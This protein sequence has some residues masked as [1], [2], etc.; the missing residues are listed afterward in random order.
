MSVAIAFVALSGLL[1][2]VW[3][4]FAKQSPHPL[5]F[6][7][8]FQWVAV[9]VFLP[10]ALI[11]LG[12]PHS[13]PPDGWLLLAAT[14]SVHGVYVI[15]LSRT[16]EAG[17]LSQVYPIMRGISPLLV[18][19]VGATVL[20]E[21]VS[22]PAW[23]GIAAI[24]GGIAMLGDWRRGT[25]PDARA[26]APWVTRMAVAVG[27]AITTYILLDKVTLHYVPAIT[28]NDG[29][30]LGNLLA[31]SWGALRSGVIRAEWTR[32]W[33][34]IILGGLLAPGSYL[35]FLASLR[36]AAVAQMAPMREIGTV[37]GT[38]FGVLV[39][40]EAHGWRRVTAAGLIAVGVLAIGLWG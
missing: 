20:D 7:W 24:V 32:R 27:L 23:L 39:L 26:Q 34:T 17:D 15:L 13:I 6:L 29:C 28:L 36:L 5:V 4:L 40:K 37:F 9:L 12:S 2:A 3:N 25:Q 21:I 1:Q 30:N 11:P 10:W 8:S 16:Y 33:Q 19:L 31:L 18:P 22:A 38:G 35:L 14:A